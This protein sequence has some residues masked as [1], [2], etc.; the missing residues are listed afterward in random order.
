MGYVKREKFDQLQAMK[1]KQN[2]KSTNWFV[3]E[4]ILY[5]FTALACSLFCYHPRSWFPSMCSFIQ[6]LTYFWSC[7][8]TPKFLFIVANV[9]VVFLF[10]E[11]IFMGSSSSNSASQYYEEYVPRSR[12][13][14]SSSTT[15]HDHHEVKEVK[16]IN[17]EG[18]QEVADEKVHEVKKDI[19]HEE[20]GRRD[21]EE[22]EEEEAGELAA[23][24]LN[25]RVEEFIARVN[26][27]RWL[28]ARSLLRCHA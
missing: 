14:A 2:R 25:K 10:G 23:E 15:T 11:S 1:K 17:E 16:S 7:L 26:K 24:E 8:F 22:E 6:Q 20:K 5:S 3:H 27:Q 18:N 9:I 21:G 19:D 12:I 28:E 4:L 13:A